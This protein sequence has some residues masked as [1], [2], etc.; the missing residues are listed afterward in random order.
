[1][2]LR[3]PWVDK[4]LR[5]ATLRPT[6]YL[7]SL[8]K[9]RHLFRYN[10]DKHCVSC[11]DLVTGELVGPNVY[12]E[13]SKIG[14]EVPI[15]ST[16]GSTFLA[17]LFAETLILL[18]DFTTFKPTTKVKE[19]A[20]VLN[21][22]YNSIQW[23][24]G[25]FLVL[26]N[27]N[28]FTVFSLDQLHCRCLHRHA[29]TSSTAAYLL[30]GD[31][32][33]VTTAN[34]RSLETFQISRPGHS[35]FIC[36]APVTRL[37][38][39][40]NNRLYSIGMP[41]ELKVSDA[42]E[43]HL[44]AD[45]SPLSS[46]LSINKPQEM[47]KNT[48]SNIIGAAFSTDPIT[49]LYSL[50]WPNAVL[51]PPRSISLSI[52]HPRLPII[53]FANATSPKVYIWSLGAT[54]SGNMEVDETIVSEQQNSRVL[55]L[56]FG[57]DEKERLYSEKDNKSAKLIV[58][59]GDMVMEPEAFAFAPSPTSTYHNLELVTLQLNQKME[60]P[61]AASEASSSKS[62]HPSILDL[63]SHLL[64]MAMEESHFE[65][66]L[67]HTQVETTP[68]STNMMAQILEGISSLHAKM[69]LLISRHQALEQRVDQISVQIS[70]AKN[71]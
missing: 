40:Q 19:T 6:N 54:E 49:P 34:G 32:L 30:H 41:V 51:S 14:T 52:I 9:E 45:A 28:Q 13:D 5:S 20:I 48:S 11:V 67:V 37:H 63:K 58:L 61:S 26:S 65:D 66:D 44:A 35:T 71:E 29:S 50:E 38:A 39:H 3:R 17:L 36:D 60:S 4:T 42:L 33:S 25:D 47:E 70:S 16:N 69:D 43:P 15:V 57:V 64:Q 68:P 21:H 10:P 1:M 2:L 22:R 23:T 55:G 7:D 12:L 24:N 8:S 53:A 46:L 18:P 31:N 27:A 62:D 56:H 59:V